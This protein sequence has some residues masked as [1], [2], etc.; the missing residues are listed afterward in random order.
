MSFQKRRSRT[1]EAA[2]K[3]YSA[4]RRAYDARRRR[5]L[6]ILLTLCRAIERR[7]K[8]RIAFTQRSHDVSNLLER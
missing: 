5:I 2:R 7:F 8:L 1:S 3:S 6:L 4:A